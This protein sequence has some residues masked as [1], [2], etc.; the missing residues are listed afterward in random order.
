[1]VLLFDLAGTQIRLARYEDDQ[2]GG[3]MQTL[4]SLMG[5]AALEKRL[6]MSPREVKDVGGWDSELIV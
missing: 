3:V 1:M 6:G 5:S 2:L 4:E